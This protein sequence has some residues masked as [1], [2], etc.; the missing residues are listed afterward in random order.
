M[1]A[2]LPLDES[3]R[4]A[5][6]QSYEVLDTPP[7]P[8]FDDLAQIAAMICGT[9]IALVSL[10]DG[11]RQW[12]KARHGIDAVETARDVAFCAHAIHGRDVFIVPDAHQDL[13]FANNPLV[14]SDPHVR[15]YAGAPLVNG[16][17]YALGT[18]CVIDRE[19]KQLQPDQVRALEALARQ[20]VTQMELRRHAIRLQALLAE[21]EQAQKAREELLSQL[22]H[23]QR[24]QAVGTLA[25]GLA[26][27]IDGPLQTVAE[28]L[29]YARKGAQTLI[30]LIGLSARLDLKPTDVAEMAMAADVPFVESQ[31]PRAFSRCVEGVDRVLRLTDAL[32]RFAGQAGTLGSIDLNQCLRDTLLVCENDYRFVADV[33]TEFGELPAVI[34]D[35]ADINQVFRSLILNAAQAIEYT[36][37]RGRIAVRSSVLGDSAV[38]RIEDNGCGISDDIR[39]RVF[40]PFFTTRG[41]R[42]S[43]GQGLSIARSIV[44]NR[45]GGSMKFETVAGLGTRFIVRLPLAG[46]AAD[47]DSGDSR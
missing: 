33:V 14:T 40:D 34:A 7:E 42:S 13:R 11:E 23:A 36:G 17:G 46:P 15:F 18:L 12:F 22:R 32:R 31:L 25:T 6:L 9:P 29:D 37:R 8:A 45:H 39:D 20:T 1:I 26:Q 16:E 21:R 19:P 2:P 3:A 35:S 10:I 44:V 38:I 28:N 27:E 4:L 24:L 41:D 47:P 5:A 43:T 30:G